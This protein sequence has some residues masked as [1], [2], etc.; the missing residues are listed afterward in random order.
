MPLIVTI[1]GAVGVGKTTLARALRHQ[2]PDSVVVTEP[3]EEWTR[4]GAASPLAALYA[5]PDRNAFAFQLVVLATKFRRLADACSRAPRDAVM[6]VERCLVA[7]GAVFLEMHRRRGA[8]SDLEKAAYDQ[9]FDVLSGL[10]GNASV[11]AVV[12]LHAP[13]RVCVERAAA[14]ARAEEAGAITREFTDQTQRAYEDWLAAA[15]RAGTPVL[16][17]EANVAGGA[18][19][20]VEK[21]AGLVRRARRA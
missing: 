5:D 7:D 21:I 3:V 18:P 19:A 2:F 13:A 20:D 1:E 15:E 6:F 11:G 9:L 8:V 14:R 10:C 16:R 12:Y 17:L 4:G